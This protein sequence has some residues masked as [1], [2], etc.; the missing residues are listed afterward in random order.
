MNEYRIRVTVKNNLLLSAIEAAGYKSQTEFAAACG[1]ALTSINALVAMRQRPLGPSGEFSAIAK[2]VMET[3]GA[4]PSD[5]WTDEQL[6]MQ[7][8]RN[9]GES[10]LGEPGLRALLEQHVTA[11]TLPSPEDVAEQNE[12][13]RVVS[14]VLS[15]LTAQ[16]QQVIRMRFYG[17]KT[18]AEVADL[19]G[20]TTSRVMQVEA[21]ALNKL[22]S[23]DKVSEAWP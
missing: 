3:L 17:D 12:A 10:T 19:L 7:L 20:V 15:N 13:A 14:S 8:R 4:A 23:I 2:A 21:A 11:M 18:F 1:V 22:R 9:S 5:L 6:S 16:Q